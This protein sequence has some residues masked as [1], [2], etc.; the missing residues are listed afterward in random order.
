[1]FR[2]ADLV[3]LL[4]ALAAYLPQGSSAASAACSIFL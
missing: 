2:P 4:A 1:L 3:G